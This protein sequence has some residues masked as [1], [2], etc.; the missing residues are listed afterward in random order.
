MASD[1]AKCNLADKCIKYSTCNH[2]QSK[3]NACYDFTKICFNKD[4]AM[5]S[6]FYEGGQR[7]TPK[8]SES[9]VEGKIEGNEEGLSETD[10]PN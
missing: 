1:L 4:Y 5:Y 9:G 6:E 8:V 3:A 2:G 10:N 7:D